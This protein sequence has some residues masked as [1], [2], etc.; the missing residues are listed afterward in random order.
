MA[1]A[2]SERAELEALRRRVE[3]LERRLAE[4]EAGRNT[5]KL[6]KQNAAPPAE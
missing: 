1:M 4:I 2:L 6:R 3:E 5:L